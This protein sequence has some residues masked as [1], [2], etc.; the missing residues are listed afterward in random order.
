MKDQGWDIM[1]LF[2]RQMRRYGID[3]T[4]RIIMSAQTKQPPSVPVEM[5]NMIYNAADVGVNTCKGEGHGLVNH[6]HAACGV[7]QIV[8]NTPHVR[9]SSRELVCSSITP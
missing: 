9:R 8:P 6:E 2:G 3:P 5:L 4:N 1:N 7:P